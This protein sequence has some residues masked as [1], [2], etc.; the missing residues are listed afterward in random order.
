MICYKIRP[1][2]VNGHQPEDEH[3]FYIS[4]AGPSLSRQLPI[5]SEIFNV[6]HQAHD[7]TP[8]PR[9]STTLR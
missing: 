5:G 7:R 8:N 6:Q 3:G 4:Q 1:D 9:F 2:L